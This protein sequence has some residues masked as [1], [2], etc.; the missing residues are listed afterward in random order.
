MAY[1]ALGRVKGIRPDSSKP[2]HYYADIADYLTFDNAVPFRS[3]EKFFE[4]AMKSETGSVSQGA[5]RASVRHV[6]DAEFDDILEAGFDGLLDAP[7][8]LTMQRGEGFSEPPMEIIRPRIEVVLSRPFRDRVFAK[9]IQSAY[10]SRCAITGLRIINGG[11]KAEVQAAHIKP[12]GENG[13]DLVQN[14][15]ALSGTVH[16]MFDRGLIAIDDDFR[17]LKA[18]KHLPSDADRLF[19]AD[20]YMIPPRGNNL[21]PHAQF[22]R[23]HRE[24]RFKG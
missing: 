14:G 6:S 23:W 5:S 4:S 11:G 16:W 20:G 17:I 24:N 7:I 13:P 19:N 3:G 8:Q 22:L 2:D 9:Q 21:R 15:L 1:F 10:D 18:H 12:V